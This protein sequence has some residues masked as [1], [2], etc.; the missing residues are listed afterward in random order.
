MQQKVGDLVA[1]GLQNV[2]AR[3]LQ[4]VGDDLEERDLVL[5]E[6][7]GRALIEGVASRRWSASSWSRTASARSVSAWSRRAPATTAFPCLSK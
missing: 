1:A 4:L 7:N 6:E 2:E 5:D 3:I